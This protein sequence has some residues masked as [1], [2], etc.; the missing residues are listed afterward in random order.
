MKFGMWSNTVFIIMYMTFY[1]NRTK[2]F[3]D[4]D[5]NKHIDQKDKYRTIDMN[6]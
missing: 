6:L 5:I 1:S 4:N 3:K 2:T